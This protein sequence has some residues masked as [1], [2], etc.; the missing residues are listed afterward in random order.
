VRRSANLE[1]IEHAR[2]GLK[3]IAR[4]PGSSGLDRLELGLQL[5]LGNACAVTKGYATPE[6]QTAFSRAKDLCFQTG[7]L[8]DEVFLALFGLW[9]FYGA[10]GDVNVALELALQ[11]L[12][13]AKQ[14]GDPIRMHEAHYVYG[15]TVFMKGRLHETRE[16]LQKA[17]AFYDQDQ[18]SRASEYGYDL[19]VASMGYLALTLWMLGL[20]DQALVQVKT[21]VDLAR[22][23]NHPHTLVIALNFLARLSQHRGDRQ[24]TH[25]N[26]TS[27]TELAAEKGFA[28]W[29]AIGAILDGWSVADR[30]ADSVE[31]ISH[32]I[33]A[34]QATGSELSHTYFLSLLAE[35]CWCNKDWDQGLHAVERGL[36][37][38]RD[39]GELV[40]A[41][42]LYRLQGRLI[43]GKDPAAVDDAE[44]CYQKALQIAREQSARGWELRA[45]GN[46]AELWSARGERSAAR[47]L[48]EQLYNGFTEGFDTADSREVSR[49]LS[50]L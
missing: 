6:A 37:G 21:S 16:H 10:R 41:S 26:A 38:V 19:A 46:L 15:N 47:Q 30:Q 42:E 12:E 25:I 50:R 33:A 24:A 35:A 3:L 39:R 9:R 13:R 44:A 11:F 5:I 14:H 2:R 23:L 36:R 49:L 29:K 22:S 8:D 32:A 28:Y 27:S 20:P 31:R 43:S 45:A 48:L 17:I 34:H 18:P 7:S 1:A 40:Y 4:L